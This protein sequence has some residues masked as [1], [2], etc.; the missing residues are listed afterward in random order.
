MDITTV[1]QAVDAFY[2]LTGTESDDPALVAHGEAVDD[3]VYTF[4]TMGCRDAQRWML[5]MGYGGWRQ[6]SAALTFSGTDA[7]DGGRY[8][9][10]PTDFLRAFGNNRVSPL[11][12]ANGD[13][14]GTL[15]DDDDGTMRGNAI[16]V[17]GEQLWLGRQATPPTTLYLD[18]HYRHPVWNASTTIDFP[19]DARYLIV[20][21]AANLAMAE[22]WLPGDNAMERKIEV[23]LM[24]WRE[25][26]R[27]IARQTKQ[28]RQFAK[29]ARFGNHW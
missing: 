4:L 16:Y 7:A 8:V 14:W 26:V 27:G 23:A 25:R 5:K 18:Y 28:P 9:A 1:D 10:L 22:N 11:V 15:I 3:V 13:R 21:E 2:R 20:A 29:A 12:E 6:R 19:L 24:R 17:R